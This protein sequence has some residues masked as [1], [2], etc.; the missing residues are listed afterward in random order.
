MTY[1]AR[2]VVVLLALISPGCWM[3]WIFAGPTETDFGRLV[4][5]GVTQRTDLKV[6]VPWS[7]DVSGGDGIYNWSIISGDVRLAVLE[8]PRQSITPLSPGKF[9]VRVLTRRKSKPETA[10]FTGTA[11]P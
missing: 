5:R 1:V 6:G 3:S 4:V 2:L 10:V 11:S 7:V 8:G 9:Q